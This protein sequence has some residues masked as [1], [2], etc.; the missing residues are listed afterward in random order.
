MAAIFAEIEARAAE[1]KGGKAGLMALMPDATSTDTLRTLPDDRYFAVMTRAI[2]NA[3][4][5][6]RI[7][8][9]KWPGFEKVFKGFDIP[10]VLAMTPDEWE[11]AQSD[12]R[13]IR[14]A[15]KISTI[16]HNAQFIADIAAE[17]G[18][19]GNF[20][21]D[22][23]PSRQADLLQLFKKRAKRLGGTSVQYFLRNVGY[24]AFVYT[25]DVLGA[26]QAAGVGNGKMPTSQ[27]AA[28]AVQDAFNDWH[29]QTGYSYAQLSRILACSVGDNYMHASGQSDDDIIQLDEH[30]L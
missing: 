21:A 14:H 18:S 23:P 7:V 5:V 15:V 28:T 16:P 22:F 27:K 24:D 19:F 10:A 12:T 25:K 6:W 1:R 9:N 3:G 13:I 4:M 26:L 2:F 8:A 20:L 17:H 30:P 29:N 11:S